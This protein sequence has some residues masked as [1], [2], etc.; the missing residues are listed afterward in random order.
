MDRNSSVK[1]KQIWNP[2]MNRT[3]RCIT[4]HVGMEDPDVQVPYTQNPFKSH[5]K[6]AMMKAHPV[7]KIGC[8]VCHDG[9]GQATTTEAAHG[10]VHAWDYPMQKKRGGIDFTQVTC[11]RCHEPSALPEGTELL[12]AGNALF[13]KYGCMGCHKV[14]RI[15]PDGG[16]QGPELSG[17]GSKTESL[18]A[19]THSFEHVK[20]VD[21]Y[22]HTTKFQWLYQHFLDPIGV[23]PDNPHTPDFDGT[24]MPNFQMSQTEAKV[25]SVWVQ[26]FRD[27]A[28][29]NI[30][31]QWIAKGPGKYSEVK[32]AAKK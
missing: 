14:G 6:V 2:Q 10:W 28:V 9:Q 25:L 5:P 26:S 21:H 12:L 8:T 30:P 23:T 16:T 24:V 29:E 22:E 19:N 11:T 1:I 3:D 15:S 13:E 27:A 18:F 31:S 4:C 7:N 17:L 20:A 32:A